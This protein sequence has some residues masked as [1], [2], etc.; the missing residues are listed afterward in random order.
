[1]D[2]DVFVLK[3]ISQYIQYYVSSDAKWLTKDIHSEL[4]LAD[5][6]QCA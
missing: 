2:K 4:L 1:M 3:D 6:Y 5:Y